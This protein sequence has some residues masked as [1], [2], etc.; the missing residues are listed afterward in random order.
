[1][2]LRKYAAPKNVNLPNLDQNQ[3][4]QTENES[5]QTRRLRSGKKLPK[6]NRKTSQRMTHQSI[7]MKSKLDL[8][9]PPLPEN[10]DHHPQPVPIT[11][12]DSNVA[13]QWKNLENPFSYSH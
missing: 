3:P 5:N 12:T 4:P 11:P 8:P 1:M 7:S 13:H 9:E 6:P 10:L 2:N